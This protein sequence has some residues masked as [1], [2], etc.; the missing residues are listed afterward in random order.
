MTSHENKVLIFITV[1]I[2]NIVISYSSLQKCFPR[3]W[4]DRY[5]IWQPPLNKSMNLQLHDVCK[6]R[7]P[8]A[9]RSLSSWTCCY[10]RMSGW[11]TGLRQR[12]SEPETLHAPRSVI[13][14]STPVCLSWEA[15]FRQP[16]F[17]RLLIKELWHE[18][19]ISPN[20]E[21]ETRNN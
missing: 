1:K 15:D 10:C 5:R 17:V 12:D 4:Q 20:Y 8:T 14:P 9:T 18:V 3:Q 16:S 2:L 7:Q 19:Q 13:S 11:P 6:P 21:P